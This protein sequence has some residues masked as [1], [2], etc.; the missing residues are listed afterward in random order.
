[1]GAGL[2]ANIACTSRSPAPTTRQQSATLKTGHS[3]M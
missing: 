2:G 1:M 3:I